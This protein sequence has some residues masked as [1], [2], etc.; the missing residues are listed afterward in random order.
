MDRNT[1]KCEARVTH[2]R[3]TSLGV[4][5]E[6]KNSFKARGLCFLGEVAQLFLTSNLGRRENE[7]GVA[8]GGG[9]L[10]RNVRNT[11]VTKWCFP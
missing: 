10:R 3:A 1:N 6:K 9:G 8:G 11:V 5:C 7:L 4:K 2:H